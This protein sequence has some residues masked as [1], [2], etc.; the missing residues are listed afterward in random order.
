MTISIYTSSVY[1]RD[2]Y[3]WV[4]VLVIPPTTQNR[5]QAY[6]P[7][8]YIQQAYIPN[9]RVFT[10]TVFSYYLINDLVF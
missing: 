1:I 10:L 6:I 4:C 3:I 7:C 5:Q 8:E 2:E 9:R